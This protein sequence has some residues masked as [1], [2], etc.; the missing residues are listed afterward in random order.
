[1][2]RVYT[3]VDEITVKRGETLTVWLDKGEHG[4]RDV[5]QVELR[6]TGEGVPQVFVADDSPA[7]MI[8]CFGGWKSMQTP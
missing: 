8:G 6:L 4:K 7:N 3:N 5:L 1:M 2:P